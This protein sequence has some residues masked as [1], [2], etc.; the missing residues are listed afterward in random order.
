[1]KVS[2]LK[3][4]KIRI[5]SFV[6]VLVLLLSISLICENH[7]GDRFEQE[8][9]LT[10]QRAV[11]QLC[12]YFD[13][14][15]TD[16]VK[17]EYANSVSMVSKIGARLEKNA[18]GAKTALASLDAGQTQLSNI[19]MYLSQAGAY[20]ASL[21]QKTALGEKISA[22]E[23]T[24]LQELARYA[25]V[26][27]EKF[28]FMNDLMESGSFSFDAVQDELADTKMENAVSYLSAAAGAE[29]SFAD[30]PTLLYD[31]PFSDGVLKKESAFLK[32]QEK[33][34][35][36]TAKEKAAAIL[37]AQH[38]DQLVENGEN[39]G[40]IET[41]N[42][43]YNGC[44]AQITKHG[45]HLNL[46]LHEAFVGESV[47][48][49]EQAVEQAAAFLEKCGYKNM[50]SSYYSANDGICTVNFAGSEDGFI[51]YPDLIKVCVSLA[52]GRILSVDASSYLMNHTQRDAPTRTVHIAQAVK[53]LRSDLRIRKIRKC[54]IPTPGGGETHA[55]E[56]LCTDADG[57][58]ALIYIDMETGAEDEIF[59]LLYSDGGTLTK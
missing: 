47:Y 43:Y 36:H 55:Y 25:G 26:L 42:F 29:E 20:V 50:V 2:K 16:L 30:Y 39:A 5:I 45:G 52:D 12:E 17:C 22:E 14:M 27:Y 37:G 24:Q 31:G 11:A 1:M 49:G 4:S 6:T 32:T 7:R 58:D 21:A 57:Q 15:H 18:A 13:S 44:E 48:S 10:R 38:P 9:N 19:Y 35:L 8:V 46:L 51:C 59:L 54:V 3:R 56:F 23:R 53:A 34:S 33:V 41:Y 28:T 40:K